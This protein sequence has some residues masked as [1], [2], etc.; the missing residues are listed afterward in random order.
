VA[1]PTVLAIAMIELSRERTLPADMLT[2]ATIQQIA[3]RFNPE[4]IFSLV[5]TSVAQPTPTA[6]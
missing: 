3:A 4:K 6:P 2:Q 5:A 1:V